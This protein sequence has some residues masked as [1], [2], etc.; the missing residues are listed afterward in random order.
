MK[1]DLNSREIRLI[2]SE[3]IGFSKSDSMNRD[4]R[5]GMLNSQNE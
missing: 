3:K 1:V 5:F 4:I 2:N